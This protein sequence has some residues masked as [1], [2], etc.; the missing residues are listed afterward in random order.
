VHGIDVFKPFGRK[1]FFEILF[2][3]AI[4]PMASELLPPLIDK[5]PVLIW[6]LWGDTV[7][8]DVEL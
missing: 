1:S 7:F 5:E 3:D 2:T 4:D 8:P 6:R